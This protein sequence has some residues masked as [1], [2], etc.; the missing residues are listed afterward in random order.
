MS[1]AGS[2]QEVE[3]SSLRVRIAG[4]D[5]AAAVRG[6]NRGAGHGER[7]PE[8][9]VFHVEVDATRVWPVSALYAH[10]AIPG[11]EDERKQGQGRGKPEALRLRQSSP[12]NSKA[13]AL[14]CFPSSNWVPSTP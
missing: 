13:T 5:L 4:D 7:I 3:A 11:A 14:D 9:V 8:H 6:I 2:L 10:N 1:F 12:R